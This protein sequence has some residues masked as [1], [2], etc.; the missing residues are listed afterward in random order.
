M[1]VKNKD[2]T[3]I[4]NSNDC[5]LFFLKISSPYQLLNGLSYINKTIETSGSVKSKAYIFF[6]SYWNNNDDGPQQM[7]FNIIK[8]LEIVFL[9]EV[10]YLDMYKRAVKGKNKVF[11]ILVKGQ[12]YKLHHNITVVLI[13]DG[14]GSYRSDISLHY[15]I[16]LKEIIALG[17]KKQV[18]FIRFYLRKTFVLL[19]YRLFKP[20]YHCMFDYKKNNFT[21][22]E[23][24]VDSFISILYRI[25]SGKPILKEDRKIVVFLSQ[26]Y[27]LLNFFDE[28]EYS[29]FLLKISKIVTNRGY[30]LY[31]KKHSGDNYSYKGLNI[32]S[33]CYVAE[34][35][36]CAEKEKIACVVSFGSTTLINA[37]VLFGLVSYRIVKGMNEN[38]DETVNT[39]F[40]RYTTT[41][42]YS[43]ILAEID[44]LS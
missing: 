1:I 10:S 31:I 37:S 27:I 5:Q 8:N 35:F 2:A 16:Y 42:N 28:E 40:L 44:F 24:Y 14:I 36:L 6:K 25:N 38:N 43:D 7:C 41:I 17:E 21:I 20:S 9:D 26:P 15:K 12:L 23:V 22:N 29:L 4:C 19:F 3:H 34:N 39:F 13:D 18:S 32:I 33:D 11:L 30:T